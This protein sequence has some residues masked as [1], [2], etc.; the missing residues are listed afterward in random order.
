[1]RPGIRAQGQQI[2]IP[3]GAASFSFEDRDYSASEKQEIVSALY[4][5]SGTAPETGTGNIIASRDEN[6]QQVKK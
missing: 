3:E 4:S 1:M 6:N 2:I 5:L